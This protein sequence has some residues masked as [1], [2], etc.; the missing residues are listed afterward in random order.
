MLFNIF[1]SQPWPLSLIIFLAYVVAILLT[2]SLHNFFQAFTAYRQ[3]DMTAKAYGMLSLNPF[4][5]IST[6]GM[7][8]L[9]LFGFGWSKPVPMNPI[10][11]KQGRKGAIKVALSGIIGNLITSIIFSFFFALS[12]LITSESSFAIFL[13]EF[14]SFMMIINFVFFVFHLLPIYPLDMFMVLSLVLK[15]NNKFL[16]FMFRWGILIMLILLLTGLFGLL[17]NVM[18]L[19]ILSPLIQ[20]WQLIL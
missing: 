2:L 15:P 16:L 3:G 5:H 4:R 18:Q 1:Y 10:Q 19:Y 12:L 13:Q 17:V 8:F 6:F 9:I 20:L 14:C 7:I 11:F